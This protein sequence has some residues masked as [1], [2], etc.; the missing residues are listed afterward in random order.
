MIKKT[1]NAMLPF[2]YFILTGLGLL[3]WKLGEGFMTLMLTIRNFELIEGA[4]QIGLVEI[5]YG[6]AP[7]WLVVLVAILLYALCYATY[8]VFIEKKWKIRGRK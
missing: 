3:F 4:E 6:E 7:V 2:I 5:V 8:K 1:D